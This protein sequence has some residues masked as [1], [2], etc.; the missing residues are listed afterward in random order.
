MSI[1]F[2]EKATE[3]ADTIAFIV[4]VAWRKYS[5][6]KQLNN[7]YQWISKL[8]IPPGSFYTDD[9]ATYRV[10]TEF[11]IWTKI[12]NHSLNDM[13]IYNPPPIVHKDFEMWQY[14]NTPEALKVFDNDFDFAVLRQGYG[15]YSK[16]IYHA[17]ECAKNKQ[18]ILFKARNQKALRLLQRIDFTEMAENN[19]ITPGFGKAD[20]V[21]KYLEMMND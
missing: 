5:V 2:F 16:K 17:V 7:Q 4:P 3:I 8:A 1:K 14:N 9:N 11:Q 19:T 6:H 10:N 12:Q 21:A 20:V 18:W 13:R 15:D